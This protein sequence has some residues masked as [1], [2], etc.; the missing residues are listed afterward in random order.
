MTLKCKAP[1][2]PPLPYSIPISS[3]KLHSC[4]ASFT[5][6]IASSV[7]DYKHE[8]GRRYH[9]YREGAYVFPNDDKESDRL[10][11]MHKLVEVGM[12]NKLYSA[13]LPATV[14]RILDIGTGTGI[15]AIEMAD[16][17]PQ[18]EILGN[19]LSPIQ[20]RW[21]PPNVRFEV[22]DVEEAWT[23][24]QP[25]DF[26]FCRCMYAALKDWPALIRRCFENVTPGGHAEFIDFD[27]L[28]RSP[29]G[30]HKGTAMEKANL[31]F[32]DTSAKMLGRDPCPGRSL[33]KWLQE[34]GFEDV[35]EKVMVIPSGAS[36]PQCALTALVA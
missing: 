36:L 25:F 29:D 6:S 3:S 21:V 14:G 8:H 15:W 20:P 5:T 33:K 32:L 1:I 12:G 19:D 31:G 7:V 11:I 16:R 18:A 23:Y 22:D 28:W 4:S 13:P 17:F 26:I 10:D 34:A 2:L 9:A 35:T 24:A 30:S 27:L